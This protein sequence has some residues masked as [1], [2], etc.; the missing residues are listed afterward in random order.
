V[1][2]GVKRPAEVVLI[3]LAFVE[4]PAVVLVVA[5]V[6]PL[7]SGG[8]VGQS[9]Q[10]QA[11]A[12]A[13]MNPVRAQ[14]S[15]SGTRSDACV[16]ARDAMLGE[17]RFDVVKLGLVQGAL[18]QQHDVDILDFFVCPRSTRS[19]RSRS[20]GSDGLN[21]NRPDGSAVVVSWESCTTRKSDSRT[22]SGQG[23]RRKLM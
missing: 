6:E 8:A 15:V 1:D 4:Q 10:L 16:N 13:G 18:R 20:N 21:S 23:N 9:T 14:L 11:R 2:V 22:W 17:K 19:R 3:D 5:Y 12:D 7:L